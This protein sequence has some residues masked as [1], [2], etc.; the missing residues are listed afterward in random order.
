MQEIVR[1]Q[2]LIDEINQHNY[3][4]YVL[5]NPTISDAEY[6]SLIKEVLKYLTLS[7]QSNSI[8]KIDKRFLA[9]R[10]LGYII[11]HQSEWNLPLESVFLN[12]RLPYSSYWPISSE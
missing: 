9:R 5:D 6:D 10:S 12:I 8:E 2:P 3:N 7:N 4:Y 1:I 11:E